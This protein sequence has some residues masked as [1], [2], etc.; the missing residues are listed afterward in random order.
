MFH[1]ASENDILKGS[2][3]DAYFLRTMEIL[4]HEDVNPQIVCEVRAGSFPDGWEW[5]VFAGLGEAIAL[6]AALNKPIQARALPE[7]SLCYAQEPVL[8][9]EGCYQD[10]CIYET[11][12]L[13]LLCQAS[14]IAT[15]AARCKLAA[16][17]RPVYSFGARRM[18][19]A[20]AP[21][22]DRNAFIGGCDGVSGVLCA[23]QLGMPPVGTMPHS[24][25]LVLGDTVGAILAFDKIVSKNI[26]RIALIDTFADEK[27]EALRVAEAMGKRLHGIRLDTPLSRRG[28]YPRLLEEVRWELDLRGFHNIKILV[29]GGLTDWTIPPLNPYADAY[30]VGTFISNSPVVDFSLDIVEIEEEP[31]AKRGKRSGKKILAASASGERRLFPASAKLPKGWKSLLQ[32]MI[33]DGKLIGP[34]PSAQEIRERVLRGFEKNLS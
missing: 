12:L 2:V 24:L 10:I 31:V 20:V 29:S 4:K 28:D 34:L 30:G 21:L 26:P 25:I 11:A 13:G 7:G 8:V 23:Q 16:E 18:H 14:G 1:I 33:S 5:A 9:I 15:R 19:P 22:V 32:E 17:G 3:T 27:F 6:L